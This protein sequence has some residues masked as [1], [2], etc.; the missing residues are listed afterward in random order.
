[1]KPKTPIHC[2][3]CDANYVWKVKRSFS[4]GTKHFVCSECQNYNYISLSKFDKRT[5]IALLI[6]FLVLFFGDLARGVLISLGL[7]FILPLL[8]Y[9]KNRKIEF[10]NSGIK[11]VKSWGKKIQDKVFDWSIGKDIQ[12][13]VRMYLSPPIHTDSSDYKDGNM[14]VPILWVIIIVLVV[15]SLL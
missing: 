13:L 14:L 6:I 4:S 15:I 12:K 2:I 7:I 10:F 8:S 5:N 3:Y 1:M 9:F 11:D